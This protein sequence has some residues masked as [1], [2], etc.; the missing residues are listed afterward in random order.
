MTPLLTEELWACVAVRQLGLHGCLVHLSGR[1][2]TYSG[3]DLM[4][5]GGGCPGEA[6]TLRGEREAGGGTSREELGGEQCLGCKHK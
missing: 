4:Y 6:H 1:G 5:Q 3:R 2:F